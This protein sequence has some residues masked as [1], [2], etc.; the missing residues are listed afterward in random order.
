MSELLQLNDLKAIE[1]WARLQEVTLRKSEISTWLSFYE[2]RLL[3][4]KDKYQEICKKEKTL[5]S[6]FEKLSEKDIEF[7]NKISL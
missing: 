5:R 3:S 4:E 6:E 1:L 7:L 2:Q